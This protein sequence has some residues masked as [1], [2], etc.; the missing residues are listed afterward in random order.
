VTTAVGPV[1]TLRGGDRLLY[2]LG[3]SDTFGLWRSDGTA[4]GTFRL[5]SLPTRLGTVIDDILYFTMTDTATTRLAL[6]RSDGTVEGTRV[7]R[8]FS[9]YVYPE[10]VRFKGA[11]YF[12]ASQDGGMELWRTDGTA[13]GTVQ[14]TAIGAFNLSQLTVAGDRLFFTANVNDIDAERNF[15]DELYAFDGT[16]AE[17]VADI[18]PGFDGSTPGH[19]TAAGNALYFT[20]TNRWGAELWAIWFD[21]PPRMRAAGR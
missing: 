7:V 21:G 19:L 10:V 14:A 2:F 11:L 13:A 9:Y 1:N 4:A 16:T 17:R 8:A 5:S 18:N 6:W 3:S 20:A 15:G 12:A